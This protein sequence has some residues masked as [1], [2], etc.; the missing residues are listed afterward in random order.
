M[1]FLNIVGLLLDMVGS[2]LLFFYGPPQPSFDEGVGIGLENGN[3]LKDGRTVK[4]HNA[5]IR[6]L[7]SKHILI[8]RIAMILV[9]VGFA[10]Q[11]G[12]NLK[13]FWINPT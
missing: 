10:F 11:L 6:K 13:L 8:S 5:D 3:I 7:K 1:S 4:Q 2:I 9:I 12:A